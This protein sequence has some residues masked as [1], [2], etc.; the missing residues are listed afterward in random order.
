MA[1]KLAIAGGE[2]TVPEATASMV[3]L[4]SIRLF[5]ACLTRGI[6]ADLPIRR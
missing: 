1:A 5:D 2:R 6:G 3:G 4:L